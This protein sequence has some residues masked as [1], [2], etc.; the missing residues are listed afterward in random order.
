MNTFS[1]SRGAL[2]L[3]LAMVR[4]IVILLLSLPSS[5]LAQENQP[6]K[7]PSLA[8]IAKQDRERRQETTEPVRL[9]T[10]ENLG[11]LRSAR[12][13][14]TESSR[15]SRGRRQAVKEVPEAAD[16]EGTGTDESAEA[17]PSSVEYW[18]PAFKEAVENLKYAAN[19]S[20]V[21]ELRINNFQNVYFREED[22]VRRQSLYAEIAKTVEQLIQSREEEQAARQAVADLQRDA[23]KA[24]LKPGEVRDLTGKLPEKR[25][26]IELPDLVD[27]DLER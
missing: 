8:E 20:L 26:I 4:I 18:E 1:R 27:P 22:G 24:G 6:K 5:L 2:L 12:V 11:G 9:I 7:E 21:L 15:P 25:S 3:G 16:A 13:V 19:A 10:N 17:D 14:T 23:E